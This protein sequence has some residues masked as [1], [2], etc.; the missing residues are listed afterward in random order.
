MGVVYEARDE[1]LDRSVAIKRMRF[2]DASLRQRLLREARTAAAIAHP[3]ICQVYELGEESGELYIVMELLSGETLGSRIGK[4]SLPLGEALQTAL[5]ALGA[6]EALHERGI[7]HRD[8]IQ[9]GGE[10]L[11]GVAG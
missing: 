8:L 9:A 7:V 5:G 11:L 4:G 1:R 6:R 2:Q 10:R 3:N